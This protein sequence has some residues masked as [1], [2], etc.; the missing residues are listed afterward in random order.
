[1][2]GSAAY[3]AVLADLRAAYDASADARARA[4]LSAWKLAERDRV[5]AWL[6]AAGVRTL[7]EIGAGAGKDALF[8][9]QQGLA[10]TATDQSPAMVAHCR[11]KGL[12]AEVHDFLSLDTLPDRFDAVYALNCLLH[13]P[14]ADLP[15]VLAA[16]HA[17]LR[18][19]GLFYLGLYG[20]ID[21]EGVWPDDQHEPKRF[22]SSHTDDSIV[23]AVQ[24]V[25]AVDAFACIPIERD[26]D[27]H[28]QSL[29]L[30][31]VEEPLPCVR[32]G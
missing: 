21:R 15:A 26:G 5:L 17:V 28:F 22:F 7:L 13:V 29:L 32:P 27:L 9:Q 4:P 18:P 1:V 24:T 6:R 3:A 12:R 20:G 11:R 30:R 16:I 8:F 10:V 19:G 23:Q 14:R 2:P 31:R 25:F